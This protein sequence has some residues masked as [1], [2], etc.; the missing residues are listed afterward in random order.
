MIFKVIFKDHLRKKKGEGEGNNFIIII[1]F[2]WLQKLK[3]Q[4]LA[5]EKSLYNWSKMQVKIWEDKKFFLTQWKSWGE[6]W[7]TI[8][9]FPLWDDLW[10]APLRDGLGICLMGVPRENF[11]SNTHI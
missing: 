5:G 9:P 11:F 7:E 8:Y 4:E 3:T 1:I 6:F 10:I 2:K